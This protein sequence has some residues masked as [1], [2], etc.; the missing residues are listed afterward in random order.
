MT[1]LADRLELLRLQQVLTGIDFVAVR[2]DQLVIDVYFHVDPAD[3]AVSIEGDLT[4]EMVS[5]TSD[6]AVALTTVA[7]SSIGWGQVDA[8]RVLQI[9]VEEPGEFVIY[10]LA[11]DHAGVDTFFADVPLDFKAACPRLV[12]CARLEPVCPEPAGPSLDLDY[13]ARD[14]WAIRG[15]MLD[16]ASLRNPEWRDR[17]EADVLVMLTEALASVADE[18]A[19]TQD[20]FR[21]ESNLFDATQRRSQ[22]RHAQL[23]DHRI[24]DGLGAST[25]L[26]IT[27]A[28][29]GAGVVPAGTGVSARTEDDELIPF[30]VGL[31]LDEALDGVTYAI[32]ARRN[33]LEPHI[34]DDDRACLPQGS[35]EMWVLGHVPVPMVLPRLGDAPVRVALRADPSDRSQPIR[36][37]YVEVID[38]EEIFDPLF[39]DPANAAL[40]LPITRIRWEPSHAT[41]FDIDLT[42][43]VVFGNIVPATAGT[44]IVQGDPPTASFVTGRGVDPQRPGV[45]IIRQPGATPEYLAPAVERIGPDDSTV[46]LFGLGDER[47]GVVWRPAGEHTIGAGADPRVARPEVRVEAIGGVA[48]SRPW[49]WRSTL[50]G[51]SSSTPDDRHFTLDDGT[52]GPTVTHRRA[53]SEAVHDDYLSGAGHSLR[54]G[55]GEF[56]STPPQGTTFDV[57]YRSGN[58]IVG[59]VPAGAIRFL[60]A[61][62]ASILAVTNLTEVTDGLATESIED[63]RRI[64]PHAWREITY[65]AVRTED[66]AEAISRLDWVQQAGAVSRWTGSWR[67]IV[68]TPDPVDA[69][70]LDVAQR[71]EAN[72]QVDRFRQAGRDAWVGAPHYADIDLVIRLCVDAAHFQGDVRERVLHRLVGDPRHPD[73]V[74]FFDPDHFVF[75]TPLDRGRLEA[76]VQGVAGVQMVEA[77]EIRRHGHFDWRPFT[78]LRFAVGDSELVRVVNDPAFPTRGTVRLRTRGGS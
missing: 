12:D 35:T 76:A 71:G 17:N 3:M 57:W 40:P 62:V 73:G 69:S 66:Y 45:D 42:E 41:P 38:A 43:T 31:G 72:A 5:I 19:Y 33:T 75:D 37:H 20:R 63:V 65:R 13:T 23:V 25:W 9:T 10:R 47:D 50:I 74:Y 6:M 56:G 68:A 1:V 15:A 2:A 54:F 24:H 8:R 7:I 39:P 52:F 67:S 26:A 60:E 21:W 55:D 18:I 44:A 48:G 11:I 28:G 46:Y 51:P 36:T 61:P 49:A 27:A 29:S 78:E 30:A 14:F 64:A 70:T 77:I 32:D 59:N 22:R 58:G 16:V 34:P 4:A 53:T